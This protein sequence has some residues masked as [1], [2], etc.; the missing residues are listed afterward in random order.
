MVMVGHGQ[1]ADGEVGGGYRGLGPPSMVPLL[2]PLH[3]TV[4]ALPGRL[5]DCCWL[6]GLVDDLLVE[7]VVVVVD[8]NT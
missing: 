7:A 6:V 3:L 5:F 2:E 8:G 1:V 4:Q